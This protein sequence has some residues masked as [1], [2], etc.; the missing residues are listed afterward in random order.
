M[1]TLPGFN[2]A[3]ILVVETDQKVADYVSAVL[4]SGGYLVQSVTYVGE[5]LTIDHSRFN[6][7]VVNG[8][9]RDA[10]GVDI[11]ERIR[12]VT[13]FAVLPVLF[14]NLDS[15]PIDESELLDKVQAM[16]VRGANHDHQVE[17][18]DEVL[19]A[20]VNNPEPMEPD[21]ARKQPLTEDDIPTEPTRLT[22]DLHLKQQ[23][24]ELKILANLARS[25]SSVLELSE[26][27]NQIVEAATTLTQAEEGMLL[28]P[29]D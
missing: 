11:R 14:I 12:Q 22:F 3:H 16:L 29:D 9:L 6:L 1:D 15:R 21:Q 28:L 25:I 24:A 5:A 27:L 17:N 10:K 19:E 20:Q 4:R 7:A 2:L 18:W 23:L 8:A 13:T 26:V